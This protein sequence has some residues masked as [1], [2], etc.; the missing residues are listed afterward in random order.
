M[1]FEVVVFFG[2][3]DMFKNPSSGGHIPVTELMN[4]PLL[5]QG[6]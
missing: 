3:G 4:G 6:N 1:Y 5:S 2:V